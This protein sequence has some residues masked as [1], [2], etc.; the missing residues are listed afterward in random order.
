MIDKTS[1][2]FEGVKNGAEKIIGKNLLFNFI[3]AIVL[4]VAV[5]CFYV[6]IQNYRDG[7]EIAEAKAVEALAEERAKFEAEMLAERA[8]I[9]Q[10]AVADYK[11]TALY[12]EEA[13]KYVASNIKNLE[14]M[15][16][17]Y[18]YIKSADIENYPAVRDFYNNFLK[19]A[20]D[21]YRKKMLNNLDSFLCAMLHTGKSHNQH[22]YIA[23]NL[24]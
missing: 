14:C 17:M 3:C 4:F 20:N 8:K 19:Q 22:L 15:N 21:H 24:A 10:E 6:Y 2:K 7:T 13:C 11:K 16:Y 1:E 9:Q 12:R 18:T 23:D 5:S